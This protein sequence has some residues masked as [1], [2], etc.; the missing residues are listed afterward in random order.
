MALDGDSRPLHRSTLNVLSS[1]A[2]TGGHSACL[3]D[4]GGVPCDAVALGRMPHMAHVDMARQEQIGAH[5]AQV[6]HRHHRPPHEMVR[7]D[8]LRQVE[9]VMGHD[10]LDQIRGNPPQPLD[11]PCHLRLASAGRRP[12]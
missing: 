5:R 8:T 6:P 7:G 4:K 12:L 9:R 2:T 11:G 1:P 10:D 3:D